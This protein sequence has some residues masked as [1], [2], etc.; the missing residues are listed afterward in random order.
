MFVLPFDPLEVVFELQRVHVQR[1]RSKD[2]ASGH[3]G[4]K[5][6]KRIGERDESMIA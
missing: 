1:R 5:Q 3:E 2:R 6:E 4:R